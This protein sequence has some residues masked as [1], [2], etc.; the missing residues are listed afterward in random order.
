MS[1]E[2]GLTQP[3]ETTPL[4][5]RLDSGRW[6]TNRSTRPSGT[7]LV[8]QDGMLTTSESALLL[9][10]FLTLVASMISFTTL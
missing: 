10:A 6:Q 4:T 9:G 2:I 5:R 7:A 3:M 8:Q 1:R